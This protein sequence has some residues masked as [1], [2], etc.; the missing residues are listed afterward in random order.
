MIYTYLLKSEI[1]R[2]FYVGISEDVDKRLQEHNSGQLK[3]TSSKKP[4]NL[5]YYK[6]HLDYVE[7]RKHE[8]WLKKKNRRYKEY[9]AQLAP[10]ELYLPRLEQRRGDAG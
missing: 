10:P 1:D 5:V 2:S 6:E 4:W 9:L 3:V 8:K 7:A